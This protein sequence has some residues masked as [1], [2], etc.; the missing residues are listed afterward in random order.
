MTCG[1]AF[2]FPAT[3][4]L[5]VIPTLQLLCFLHQIGVFCAILLTLYTIDVNNSLSLH[6][7]LAFFL[8]FSTSNFLGNPLL[9]RLLSFLLCQVLHSL[10]CGFLKGSNKLGYD[11]KFQSLVQI[12][13]P[14]VLTSSVFK[15]PRHVPSARPQLVQAR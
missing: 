1:T 15:A 6:P 12:N 7:F 3:H 9:I 2:A 8:V 10:L 5:C 11:W 4:Y 14:M 13:N